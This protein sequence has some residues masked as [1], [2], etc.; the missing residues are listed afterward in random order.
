MPR[1][2]LGHINLSSVRM[3]LA[4]AGDTRYGFPDMVF[5][6]FSR[7]TRLDSF[8]TFQDNDG[9]VLPN[10]SEALNADL[11]KLAKRLHFVA[12]GADYSTKNR[13]ECDPEL[14]YSKDWESVIGRLKSSKR[15]DVA[16]FDNIRT[17]AR[18]ERE[19]NMDLKLPTRIAKAFK[20]SLPEMKGMLKMLDKVAIDD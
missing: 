9:N 5:A 15:L 18:Q 11:T 2:V 8:E 16:L 3:R 12:H 10:F 1:A 7:I 6:D 19:A 17:R 4:P 20:D 13:C 14:K